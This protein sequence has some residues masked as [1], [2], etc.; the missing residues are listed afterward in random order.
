MPDTATV[1]FELE[2]YQRE[3]AHATRRFVAA[4]APLSRTR[5]LMTAEP[6]FDPAV[7]RQLA[8]E[9]GIVG[10]RTPERHGGAGAGFV[11][12]GL[13]AYELGRVCY[14]GPY[15]ATIL[16]LEVLAAAGDDVVIAEYAPAL[17]SG[18]KTASV[19]W[20]ESAGPIPGAQITC[21]A[22]RN[23][24]GWLLR[25]RKQLVVNGDTADHLVVTARTDNGISLFVVPG[26]APGV[27]RRRRSSLDQT[28]ALTD[29]EFE[30]A[31][32]R[33]VGT[34]GTA[35]AAI[36]AAFDR[37]CVVLAAE[38]IG[39]ADAALELTVGYLKERR[40]FGRAI[41]SFQALKHRCADLVMAI[42]L[43]RCA[44]DYAT[45]ALDTEA[46]DI[47]AASA[48]ALAEAAEAATR[49]AGECIQMHGGIG[50]TWEHDAHLYFKRARGNAALLGTVADHRERLLQAL[51]V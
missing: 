46:E 40:Q 42:E 6:G 14:S 16:A 8:A 20:A 45:R 3:L 38:T 11:E 19:A 13:A 35:A 48:I 37:G 36:S 50:F 10:L 7:Y 15:L 5:Q 32:G 47:T 18:D 30:G 12:V 27:V 21:T 51:G 43:A 17:V 41:G 1:S 44:V 26:S 9:L 24:D 39:I 28:R 23:D 2:D 29:I 34:E 31:A 22:V 49:T 33:L 25:G 4:R